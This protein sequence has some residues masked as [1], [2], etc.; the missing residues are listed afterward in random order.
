M[1]GELSAHIDPGFR[2]AESL[3]DEFG[4]A[5]WQRFSDLIL[6]HSQPDKE[7]RSRLQT[8]KDR[9]SLAVS[10]KRL[11]VR[12]IPGRPEH[13]LPRRRII[14]GRYICAV[15]LIL[16]AAAASYHFL[17][18]PDAPSPDQAVPPPQADEQ[19]AVLSLDYPDSFEFRSNY[20]NRFIV[21]SHTV[22]AGE[23]FEQVFENLGLSSGLAQQVEKSCRGSDC[24]VQLK[25]DD[26]MTVYVSRQDHEPVRFVLSAVSGPTFSLL[27]TGDNW[28]S[29]NDGDLPVPFTS[30]LRGAYSDNFYDSCIGAGL[31]AELIPDLGDIFSWDMDINFD[32]QDGDTFIVHFEE[33]VKRGRKAPGGRILAAEMSAGSRR[34]QAFLYE[35]PDGSKEYFDAKGASLRKQFLKSPLYFRRVISATSYKPLRPVLKIYRPHLGVDYAAPKGTP[36]SSVGEGT[37]SILGRNP[38]NGRFIEISHKG[39]Y[40]TFYGQL[41]GYGKNIRKGSKV[42]QGEVIGLV[43]T[44]DSGTAPFLDFRM[45]RNGKPVNYLRTDFPPV[46]TLPRAQRQ[47]FEKQRDAF[48]AVLKPPASVD[49]RASSTQSSEP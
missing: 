5:L 13:R 3:N 24:P 18:P 2:S 25:P 12:T 28:T 8:G 33:L 23:T 40:K 14:R 26:E 29:R 44:T 35:L 27:K 49:S 4:G 45:T 41:S 43:G 6:S 9:H 21:K 37:I 10:M 16:L 19:P 22:R 15:A 17:R 7:W 47:D 20:M 48:L 46:Q 11:V 34:I 42:A 30:T 36:V 38:R 31:P 32:L 1:T 39:G